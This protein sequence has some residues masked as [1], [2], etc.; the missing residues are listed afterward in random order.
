[1]HIEICMYVLISI[2][3]LIFKLSEKAISLGLPPL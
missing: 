1:M 3:P 2:V